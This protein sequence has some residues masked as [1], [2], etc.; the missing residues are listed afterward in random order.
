[1]F[2]DKTVKA[3]Y[4]TLSIDTGYLPRHEVGRNRRALFLVVSSHNGFEQS[5]F[6]LDGHAKLKRLGGA[7]HIERKLT[8]SAIGFRSLSPKIAEMRW[9]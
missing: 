6:D 3:Y 8:H 9:R 4:C 7:V 1:M 5:V 2:I